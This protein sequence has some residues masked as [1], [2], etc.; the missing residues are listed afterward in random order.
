MPTFLNNFSRG[1]REAVVLPSS[2][3]K[4]RITIRIDHNIIAWFKSQVE[5][6][7]DGNYQTMLNDALQAHIQRQEEPIEEILRRVVREELHAAH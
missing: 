1:R 6:Q 5:A 4:T 7:G 2:E 3:T